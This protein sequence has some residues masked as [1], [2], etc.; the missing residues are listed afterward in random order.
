[1]LEADRAGRWPT[2][3]Q[4]EGFVALVEVLVEGLRIP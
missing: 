3:D 4:W 2:L 1:M